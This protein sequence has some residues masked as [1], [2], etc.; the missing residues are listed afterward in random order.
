[1]TRKDVACRGGSA[2]H[3]KQAG[4]RTGI[5]TRHGLQHE[6]CIGIDHKESAKGEERGQ[7]DQRNAAV[8]DGR[9]AVTQADPA[10]LRNR[11]KK[12]PHASQRHGT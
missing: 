4:K 7:Q 12:G 9:Q 8:A 5:A 2:P 10:G 6:A 3:E 1:M 11:A